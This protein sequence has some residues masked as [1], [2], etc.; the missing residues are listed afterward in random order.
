M[1]VNKT[2]KNSPEWNLFW[3]DSNPNFSDRWDHNLLPWQQKRPYIQF[4]HTIKLLKFHWYTSNSFRDIGHGQIPPPPPQTP[5]DQKKSS[6]DS[7]KINIW[8]FYL[9]RKLVK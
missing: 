4:Y 3:T 1:Y 6:V 2:A 5:E 8:K 7:V 9:L